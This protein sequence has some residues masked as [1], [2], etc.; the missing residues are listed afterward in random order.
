LTARDVLR[1]AA[2]QVPQ[3]T[4]AED[5]P[6][7]NAPMQV[8]GERIGDTSFT[9]E[10]ILHALR[11][12]Q[13]VHLV[14][15]MLRRTRLGLIVERGGVELLPRIGELFKQELGWNDARWAQEQHDY[16]NDWQRQHA[17]V[18]TWQ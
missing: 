14:D 12:E 4:P 2:K 16:L 17:P 18:T 7:F 8:A 3:L 1:E 9:W 13:V 11:H 6:L 15:L 10:G 5:G